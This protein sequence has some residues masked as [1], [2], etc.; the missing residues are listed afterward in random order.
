MVL[1]IQLLFAN[2]YPKTPAFCELLLMFLFDVIPYSGA[3]MYGIPALKKIELKH[4]QTL[5]VSLS[6]L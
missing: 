5:I 2:F 3:A 6:S 1:F 4:L